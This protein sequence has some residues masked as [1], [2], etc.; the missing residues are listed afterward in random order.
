MKIV[1]LDAYTLNPG[2]RRWEELEELGEVIVHDRTSPQDVVRRAEDADV[3]LT[4]KTILDRFVLDLLPK[5]KY[6]GVLATGYNVVDLDVARRRGIVVT[7][8]PAY[9]TPSVA[10]MAIA[11]LLNITQRI[12]HYANEVH[13]GV[14]SAQPDFCYWNTPLVELAGKKMGIVGF[15][16]TGQVTARIAEALGMEI[17]VYTSKPKKMLP[18]KYQKVAL[19]SL[20]S[21][22]DVVSLHC[23]L[24]PE[25]KE[26]V[27][28]YR[29]SLM[30]QGA[31]LINTSRG[32]LIDE[33][34]LE[35][36]LLSGRLLG[37]GLDVLSSEPAS[38]GNPLLKLKNCFITPHIA[39]ATRES[40]TRL[41]N[42]AVKNLKAWMEGNTIN[43][44]LEI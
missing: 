37:A 3:V 19:D 25:N 1:V 6:I 31:I 34:A 9:S 13:N 42:Q 33:K 27:N 26:M 43:N 28:S 2:E 35:Q 18:K 10:Q 22:S 36:A 39:W 24:T 15:G 30:K 44:V 14:W 20:F 23:P 7:N 21:M 11:H 17:L 41:M 16:N 12:G 32:G 5:L 4:N 29:L 38:V 8:I 40:R